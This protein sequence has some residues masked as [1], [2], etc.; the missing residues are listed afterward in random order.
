MGFEV[1][2]RE[3]SVIAA[4]TDCIPHRANMQAGGL[5]GG[6]FL[7]K[8]GYSLV[9]LK[10]YCGVKTCDHFLAVAGS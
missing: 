2:T 7:V 4:R 10:I 1:I 6:Q 3:Y 9:Q 5:N 8:I